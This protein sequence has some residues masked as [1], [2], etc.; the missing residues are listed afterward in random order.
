MKHL[1]LLVKLVSKC[2]CFSGENRQFTEAKSL[3]SGV[4]EKSFTILY[5]KGKKPSVVP[6]FPNLC[7][8]WRC[9]CPN[10][11]QEWFLWEH[12]NIFRSEELFPTHLYLWIYF[13]IQGNVLSLGIL[14]MWAHSQ[15]VPF[16]S[17][18][19]MSFPCIL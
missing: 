7:K 11:E 19:C 5:R 18:V 2:I 1:L 4:D 13:Q 16:F 10:S 12:R 3:P 6:T 14:G 17:F 15:N 8:I 9:V